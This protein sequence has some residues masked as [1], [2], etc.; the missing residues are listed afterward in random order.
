MNTAK[1]TSDRMRPER[2][3]KHT[4]QAGEGALSQRAPPAYRADCGA[5]TTIRPSDSLARCSSQERWI[6]A[7]TAAAA[8]AW[9]FLTSFSRHSTLLS[10]GEIDA[11]LLEAPAIWPPLGERFLPRH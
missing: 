5:P 1:I 6:T 10:H 4:S 2:S 9:R 11:R 8:S 3:L 7:A